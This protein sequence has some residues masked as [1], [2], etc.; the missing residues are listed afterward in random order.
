MKKQLV[1]KPAWHRYAWHSS[2]SFGPCFMLQ[3]LSLT[4]QSPERWFLVGCF[5]TSHK[6]NTHYFMGL[7][8]AGRENP[9]WD[10]VLRRWCGMGLNLRLESQVH[11]GLCLCR[12]G[13]VTVWWT[14]SEWDQYQAQGRY[15]ICLCC[16][17]RQASALPAQ[18]LEGS[19]L[20]LL[21]LYTEAPAEHPLCNLKRDLQLTYWLLL[22]KLS[23]L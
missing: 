6:K 13:S 10:S 16:D 7:L 4:V 2:F 12:T 23:L 20:G 8:V 3:F 17:S 5:H 14:L 1:R 9:S 18:M 15:C 21:L 22:C 19:W 11:P